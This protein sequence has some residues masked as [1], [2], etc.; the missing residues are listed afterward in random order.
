M[1]AETSTAAVAAPSSAKNAIP[2]RLASLDAFRGFIM[3]TMASAGFGFAK[4]AKT[5]PDWGLMQFL[6]SQFE[7]VAWRGCAFWDLIQPSFMFM[8]GVA[9]AYS[10]AM[11]AEKGQSYLGMANHAAGRALIL[12]ALGVFLS[13][14]GSKQTNFSF[15]NVLS[16]IGLGYFCLFL[17]WRRPAGVQLGA[18]LGIL[19]AYWV[20]FYRYPAPDAAFDMT[21]AGLPADWPRLSGMAAHWER[22]TNVASIFDRTFLNMFPREKRYEFNEGGYQTLNFVPSLATMIFGLMTGELLRSARTG[23]NK[24]AILVGAGLIGLAIG[25]ALDLA[26][27][28]PIVKRIWTPSWAVFSAGWALLMLAGFYLVV[29]LWGYRRLALPLVV[30]GMNSIAMY[31]MS[32]MM[33]PWTRDQLKRHFGWVL[34]KMNPELF[35]NLSAQY[36]TIIEPTV[37]M[38]AL[39]LIC[40]WLYRQRIFFRI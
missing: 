40:A 7:H 4:A 11:R 33:K 10:Y 8:V 28:C 22:N 19:V 9:M 31:M 24:L 37:V 35:T 32:Q 26:G 3:L 6:G 25:F 2:Q 30:V 29:D 27:V 15:M 17:L 36:A 20:W 18:A 13:S 12:I 38:L 34:E 39:W 16:Q 23:W 14:T 21:K 5:Y 1:A